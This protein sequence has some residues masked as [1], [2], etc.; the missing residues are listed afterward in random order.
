MA[1]YCSSCGKEIAEGIKFCPSCG[2][3]AVSEI[4]S[5]IQSQIVQTPAKI[6][7][8]GTAAV[9]SFFITGAGQ[10]YNGQLGGGI[11]LLVSAIVT[12]IVGFIIPVFWVISWGIWV[13]AIYDAYTE[14]QKINRT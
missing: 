7:D 13:L 6:K 9:L 8:P 14:A 1:K 10:I 2:K 4:P 12:F 3:A 5:Q 11:V